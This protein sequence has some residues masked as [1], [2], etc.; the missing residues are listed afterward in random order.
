[1]ADVPTELEAT[2]PSGPPGRAPSLPRGTLLGRY[3]VLGFL[4][5]GGMASV[6]AAY[7]PELDRKVALKLLKVR[8]ADLGEARA[9]LQREAQAMARLSHPNVVPVFDVGSHEGQLFVAMEFV[10]GRTLQAW[11]DERPRSQPEIVAAF[12]AAGEGLCAAHAA[13]V[14]HRDFKAENVLVGDDGR[15]RVTDFGLARL[16][17]RPA[18][19]GAPGEGASARL[20]FSG[21]VA[22][23]PAYMAP[24][25]FLGGATDARTDQFNF[26]ASL[27]EASAGSL[28]FRGESFDELKQG[29]LERQL[30]PASHPLPRWLAAVL[31]RGLQA[32]PEDRYPS[33]AEL[34]AALRRDRRRRL[35]R[36]LAAAGSAVVLAGIAGSL[37]A[38]DATRCAREARS[39]AAALWPADRAAA[40]RPGL[41]REAGLLDALSAEWKGLR[42]SACERGRRGEPVDTELTCLLGYGQQLAAVG[43]LVAE[44]GAGSDSAGLGM[45]FDDLARPQRC[46]FSRRQAGRETPSPEHLRR[47][48]QCVLLMGRGRYQDASALARSLGDEARAAGEP[49]LAA[50]ALFREARTLRVSRGA[51]AESLEKLRQAVRAADECEDD[52]L[53]VEARAFILCL[54]ADRAGSTDVG[55]EL[56]QAEADLQAWLVRVGSPPYLEFRAAHC[57]SLAAARR[58]RPEQALALAMRQ[59]EVADRLWMPGS[60]RFN[61]VHTDLAVRLSALGRFEEA[62][63]EYEQALAVL[64]AIGHVAPARLTLRLGNLASLRMTQGRNEDALALVER[65]QKALSALVGQAGSYQVWIDTLRGRALYRLGRI[66]EAERLLRAVLATP[67][68]LDPQSRLSA[69]Q[70]L[71]RMLASRGEAEQALS[72]SDEAT[73]LSERSPPAPVAGAYLHF[74]RALA[75]WAASKKPEA[76]EEARESQ[77]EF[78]KLAEP[79]AFSAEVDAWLAGRAR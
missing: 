32:R 3:V 60:E 25:Q 28:P 71:S 52:E 34:L 59:R 49:H 73:T 61:E 1:M 79:C 38:W 57:R 12:A 15:V 11:L 33:F 29:V 23:T 67:P 54:L 27:W 44:Q 14:V 62:G 7:D 70:E 51:T 53:S 9:T 24:E 41:P 56:E 63:R 55:P 40:L 10:P 5:E 48:A 72:L 66:T 77:A 46:S 30:R 69:L 13:D 36:R 35:K 8:G 21:V 37:W 45:L 26:C 58:G 76:L 64:E 20:T 4:G 18:A 16:E 42:Q 43:Q 68:D 22:G 17:P 31:S 74:T 65:A 47:A 2:A 6:F 19:A 50:L 39:E 75:L 78:K